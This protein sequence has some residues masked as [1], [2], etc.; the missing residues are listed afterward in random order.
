M[1]A[2]RRITSLLA[3]PVFRRLWVIGVFTSI[4]RWLDMLVVGI[5]AWEIT[6]SPFLVALLVLLRL[7]PLAVFGPVF[8]TLADR[9]LP[10]RM[11]G[12]GFWVA[13]LSSAIIFLL[14]LFDVVAYWHIAIA[15]VISGTMW[16]A[17]FPLRRRM[18]G[19]AVQNGD[20]ESPRDGENPARDTHHDRAGRIAAAMSLDSATN[21]A[22]RMIGPLLGGVI[23]HWIGASGAFALN[24]VLFFAAAVLLAGVPTV[25]SIGV[26]AEP[27]TRALRD[28]RDALSYAAGDRDIRSVLLITVV[29]NVWGFPFLS[30]IPVIGGGELGLSAN[31]V[32]VLVA[33]EG[34]GAFIGALLVAMNVRT[35]Q[36]RR[37]YFGGSVLHLSFVFV[38]GWMGDAL[39]FGIVIFVIGLVAAG[40]TT[41]QSTLIFTI[42]RPEMRG[43]LFGLVVACIGTGLIGNANIGLMGELFGGS[44]AIRIVAAEGLVPLLIIG[45]LWKELWRGRA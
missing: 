39:P 43:R 23:Y 15:V 12:T 21:N 11:L 31:W 9:L 8:G 10:K 41:M 25:R 33:L 38:L 2:H 37:L 40:F 27:I 3:E 44:A 16:A 4:A 34:A 42:A 18:L 1:T 26:P 36:F 24:A 29:F 32:G 6:G 22:T 13:G 5:F 30:M 20:A 28:F 45:F 35:G 17:D 19:D 7:L 14:F